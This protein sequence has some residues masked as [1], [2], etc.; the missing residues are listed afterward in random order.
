MLLGFALLILGGLLAFPGVPGPGI[1][2]LL[3]GLW[4]LSPHFAWARRALAWV[5]AKTARWRRPDRGNCDAE[6]VA[7]EVPHSE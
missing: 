3:L 6:G 2:I 4:I 5:K 7:S 1:P